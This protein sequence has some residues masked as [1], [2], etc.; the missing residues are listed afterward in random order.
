MCSSDLDG[1]LL[2]MRYINY[3]IHFCM[4]KEDTS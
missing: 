4:E 3:L 2:A 1:E